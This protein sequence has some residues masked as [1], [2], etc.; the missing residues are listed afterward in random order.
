MEFLALVVKL[1]GTEVSEVPGTL[2]ITVFRAACSV[3]AADVT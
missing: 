1:R 2:E 3:M